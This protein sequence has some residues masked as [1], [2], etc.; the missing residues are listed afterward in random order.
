MLRR[1]G[2][3]GCSSQAAVGPASSAAVGGEACATPNR[4]LPPQRTLQRADAVAA[5]LQHLQLAQPLQALYGGDLVA[6]G[7]Q[8]GQLG[9]AQGRQRRQGAHL[10]IGGGEMRGG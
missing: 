10:W 3:Q 2:V 6:G 9:A 5:Q 1:A 8:L 4:A 7:I